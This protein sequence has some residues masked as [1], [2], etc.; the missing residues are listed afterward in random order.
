M[1]RE[2]ALLER[3]VALE[4]ETEAGGGVDL[5]RFHSQAALGRVLGFL[6]MFLTWSVAP[7]D[8]GDSRSEQKY[9]D[10]NTPNIPEKS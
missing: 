5:F 4:G 6:L 8:R 2:C 1:C 9:P 7:V 3:R 10:R